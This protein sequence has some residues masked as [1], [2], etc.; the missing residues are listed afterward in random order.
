MLGNLEQWWTPDNDD[1]N[2]NGKGGGDNDTYWPYS[3]PAGAGSSGWWIVG[4]SW[5]SGILQHLF[6]FVVE[7]FWGLPRQIDCDSHAIVRAIYEFM[8][9]L[10]FIDSGI[11]VQRSSVDV[12][13]S[14]SDPTG[15][16]SAFVSNVIFSESVLLFLIRACNCI[17]RPFAHRARQLI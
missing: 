11:V 10:V 7:V 16:L 5:N 6:F 12:E 4:A 3:S 14:S 15:M 8:F 9:Q 13:S 17:N 1:N 2:D